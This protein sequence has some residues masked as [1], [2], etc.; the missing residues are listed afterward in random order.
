MVAGATGAGGRGAT[1]AKHPQ[2]LSSQQ[3]GGIDCANANDD[4]VADENSAEEE[5]QP[6]SSADAAAEEASVTTAKLAKRQAMQ[7]RQAERVQFNLNGKELHD[8]LVKDLLADGLPMPIGMFTGIM[9]GLDSERHEV[10]FELVPK[11][12]TAPSYP[13]DTAN[14]LVWVIQNERA[15]YY[16]NGVTLKF[17]SIMDDHAIVLLNLRNNLW[18]ISPCSDDYECIV[19]VGEKQIRFGQREAIQHE[20]QIKLGKIEMKFLTKSGDLVSL[21]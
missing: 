11:A 6:L 13:C 9:L 19:W 2:V 21:K 20:T 5:Q 10:G 1:G 7:D 14:F 18:W 15:D 3:A 17:L 8:E 16:T 4:G 12:A